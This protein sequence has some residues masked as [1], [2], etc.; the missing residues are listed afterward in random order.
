MM[1]HYIHQ[2]L[3]Q[4]SMKSKTARVWISSQQ[5]F[6]QVK[7]SQHLSVKTAIT[8]GTVWGNIIGIEQHARYDFNVQKTILRFLMR[9][10]DDI[11]L[12]RILSESIAAVVLLC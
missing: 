9:T 5:N 11:Y 6:V 3:S 7:T 8:N 12:Q 2:N 10:S 4:P 1:Y